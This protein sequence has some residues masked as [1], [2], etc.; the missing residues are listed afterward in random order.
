MVHRNGPLETAA[1]RSN[2]VPTTRET[3][4]RLFASAMAVAFFA[5]GIANVTEAATCP[6]DVAAAKAALNKKTSEVQAPKTRA[7]ARSQELQNPRG[8]DSQNP[9]GQETQAP[10]SLAGARSIE[11]S[12]RGQDSQ[13]PRGQDSQNPRG[14]QKQN[15]R[16]QDSQNPRGQDSQN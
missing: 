14:E 15:P 11:Q 9:R 12:P 10:R 16:G 13:N 5:A 8:Q 7:G 3:M 4:K 1:Q 6:D 2:D